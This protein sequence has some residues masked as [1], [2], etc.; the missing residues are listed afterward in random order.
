M[1]VALDASNLRDGGGRTHL[2]ELLRAADPALDGAMT[3]HVWGAPETLATLA[4]RPWLHLHTIGSANDGQLARWWWR[5]VTFPRDVKAVGATVLFAPGGLLAPAH[6]PRVT[7]SRNMLPFEP[8]ERARYGNSHIGLRLRLLHR[9]Q[10]AAFRRA[11]G[12][13]FLSEYARRTVLDDAGP[14]RGRVAVVPHGIAARFRDARVSR[15][16]SSAFQWLYVSIVDLY[17]HQHL[18]ASAVLDLA[19]AGHDV[20]LDLVGRAYAPALDSLHAVMRARDPQGRIVRYLGEI[21]YQEL[22]ERYAAAD[23]FVF[24]S[25]CENF[26]NILC[27]ALAGGMPCAV[28]DAGVMPE[29]AGDAA[30]YFD[31]TDARSAAQALARIAGDPAL[32]GELSARAITRTAG[33]TWDRCARDTFRFLRQCA[34]RDVVA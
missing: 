29:V 22:H 17:K 8:R 19:D 1:I 4:P 14:L 3:V 11:D 16:Q 9:L 25:T 13:I 7:M 12:V 33:W 34:S 6:C 30:V 26:P 24:A 20:R 23:G 32:R 15:P 21:P 2:I 18:I 27:E 28:S 5:N 31:A 10:R